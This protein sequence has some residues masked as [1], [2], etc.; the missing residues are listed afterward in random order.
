MKR[1]VPA[2][3]ALLVS[4][5]GSMN[6]FGWLA[7]EEVTDPPAELVPISN[8]FQIHQLWAGTVGQGP[9]RNRLNWFR[10]WMEKGCSSPVAMG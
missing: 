3:L 9:T 1:L 2:V 7:P 5:C 4:G 10:R 6:P 8:Q